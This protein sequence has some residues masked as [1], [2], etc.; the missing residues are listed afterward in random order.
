M[1]T[2]R[3]REFLIES[4]LDPDA[5]ITPSYKTILILTKDRKIITGIKKNEDDSGFE[6]VDK[7]GKHL[8]IAKARIKKFKTQ[9]ISSMPG[10][11]KDLLEIQEIADVL[12]YLSEQT[13][14]MFSTSVR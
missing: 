12:A 2:S 1:G 4:I 5:V 10:N 14:P 13:L 6:I 7:E 11:F 3:T 9:K 8:H